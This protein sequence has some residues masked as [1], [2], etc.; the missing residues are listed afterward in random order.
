MNPSVARFLSLCPSLFR[1][2][3]P[4]RTETTSLGCR[5]RACTPRAAPRCCRL[6]FHSISPTCGGSRCGSRASWRRSPPA[7][8]PSV[9]IFYIMHSRSE[10]SRNR[11]LSSI[12]P[13]RNSDLLHKRQKCT[14]FRCI[15]RLWHGCFKFKLILHY[16]R[17][18]YIRFLLRTL[19]TG[20]KKT[21]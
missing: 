19:E 2:D 18:L 21:G 5:P 8:N 1:P 20:Y 9:Q 12:L 7:I 4:S 17:P 6:P 10:Y 11:M 14:L 16:I 3:H 15:L 13:Q